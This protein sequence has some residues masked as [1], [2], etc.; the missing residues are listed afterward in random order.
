ME[1]LHRFEAAGLGKAP[2]RCVG[3]ERRVGP[4]NLGNGLEVGAPGQPMGCCDYCGQGIAECYAIVSADGREFIVGCD[5]VSKTGDAGLKIVVA[6]HE[7]TKRRKATE[8]RNAR[9]IEALDCLLYDPRTLEAAALLPHPLAWRAERGDTLATWALW[10]RANAGATG[11]RDVLKTL[12]KL[13][14]A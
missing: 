5:C 8:T 7:R 4:I 10:M 9:A 6:Q 1:K 2:F 13:E 12:K 3:V 11:R 14:A